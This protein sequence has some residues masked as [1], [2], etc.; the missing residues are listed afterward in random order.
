M[1]GKED[2]NKQYLHLIN[3]VTDGRSKNITNF[4]Y[5]MSDL[6]ITSKYTYVKIV[7]NFTDFIKKDESELCLDD[8]LAY[9]SKVQYTDNGK[10]TTSSYRIEVYSALKKFCQY[11][12]AADLIEKN[13]MESVKRP[14]SSESQETIIKRKSAY[15]NEYEM[16]QYVKN[17]ENGFTSKQRK[18]D[19]RW[20]KRD[21]A[22]IKIFLTTGIRCSALVKIDVNDIN[23]DTGCLYVTDKGSKVSEYL[24]PD[25]VLSDVKEWNEYRKN[26]ILEDTSALFVSKLRKRMTQKSIAKVVSKYGTGV[27][28]IKFSP[29]KLRATYGTLLY[30][31]TGDIYAV[32][33]CMGHKSPN[34]TQLYIRN[35]NDN[36]RK[37]ASNIMANIFDA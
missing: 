9:M 21:N 13:Y 3:N 10:E 23:F 8:F 26:M 7:A 18:P 19:I 25:T 31:K 22:I 36:V 28:D 5:F 12:Y 14:K 27:K 6:S 4:I 33:K 32:Q 16:K 1:S 11:L 20:Q 37:N 34:T 30:E 35:E 17:V 24:L 2:F 15:L 29:H